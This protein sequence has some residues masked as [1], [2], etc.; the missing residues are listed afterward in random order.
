LG[1]TLVGAII[2]IALIP[3]LKNKTTSKWYQ[4]AICAFFGIF[5]MFMFETKAYA[6]E[7]AANVVIA[8]MASA[9]ITAIVLGRIL[10]GETIRAT[11][12]A[13]ALFAIV[14]LAVIVGIKSSS[15]FSATGSFL[16]ICAGAGYGIFS[17]AM[18]KYGLEG[19]LILTR[20]MLIYGSAFLFI[21]VAIDFPV[22]FE[23]SYPVIGCLL[24]L[25]ILPTI[26]GFYCTT[27]AIQYLTPSK[28][29]IIELSEPIFA[30]LIALIILR[31]VPGFPTYFGGALII[32]GISLANGLL[33][34]PARRPR[35]ALNTMP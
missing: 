18:K 26:F 7:S 35:E 5:I 17:V 22:H 33:R 16:G 27:K 4:V 8:L 34:L 14:G 9:C 32:L 25:A 24:G 30:A 28:V 23:L 31:E 10:L 19:G 21:P 12:V 20:Q 3:L 13:G 11:T 29:Q 15:G 6:F 1:K 2:L